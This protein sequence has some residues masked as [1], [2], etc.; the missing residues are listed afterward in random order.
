MFRSTFRRRAEIYLRF[1][2]DKLKYCLTAGFAYANAFPIKRISPPAISNLSLTPE[3]IKPLKFSIGIYSE[4]S[5]FLK[6]FDDVISDLKIIKLLE[7]KD[8]RLPKALQQI[9]GLIFILKSPTFEGALSRLMSQ[10]LDDSIPTMVYYIDEKRGVLVPLLKSREKSELPIGIIPQVHNPIVEVRQSIGTMIFNRTSLRTWGFREMLIGLKPPFIWSENRDAPEA[11]S[12]QSQILV[13]PPLRNSAE[14]ESLIRR[15]LAINV[16]LRIKYSQYILTMFPGIEFRLN[17]GRQRKLPSI[18]AIFRGYLDFRLVAQGFEH[19]T[20]YDTIAQMAQELTQT[21]YASSLWKNN[22]LVVCDDATASF[23][24][25]IKHQYGVSTMLV[26]SQEIRALDPSVVEANFDY[27]TRMSSAL[28]Y[29]PDYLFLKM[30]GFKYTSSDFVTEPSTE[31]G[32]PQSSATMANNPNGTISRIKTR[33][34]IEFFTLKSPYLLGKGFIDS[35][36]GVQFFTQM[37]ENSLEHA[38]N[39]FIL[40]IIVPVFNNGEYLL[41]KAIPSLLRNS[42]WNSMEIIIVDDGSTDVST[43]EVCQFLSR[44]FPNVKFYSFP[45]GGSGSASRARNKGMRLASSP[46]IS[47]LDPDNEISDQG[48]DKLLNRYFQANKLFHRCDFVSGYQVK[49]NESVSVNSLHSYTTWPTRIKNPRSDFF[50]SGRFP[51]V[52]TQAAVISKDFL[53]ENDLTFVHGAIGQDTLFGWQVL[54]S[55]ANPIFTRE[56]HLIYFAERSDSITNSVGV[57]FFEKSLRRE[58][59]QV[60]WLKS[61]GLFKIYCDQKYDY[62]F[63]RWYKLKLKQVK[64]EDL[65]QSANY[66]RQIAA[67]YN[68]DSAW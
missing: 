58:Q 3:N 50:E 11:K 13:A 59:A 49:I 43:L 21:P 47:F 2:V 10:C 25:S 30:V 68:K 46:T 67:L 26:T 38:A 36:Y 64:P 55:A 35:G 34:C 23:T 5:N 48:Y 45:P 22:I 66:L 9:D 42:N 52:S 40:S 1:A 14:S 4:D 62:F 33:N 56:A 17:G 60:Q 27:V 37:K 53:L 12:A 63:D 65:D 44:L 18:S 8:S 32:N 24:K 31:I 16:P 39:T 61:N 57:N 7:C 29:P 51:T 28:I 15:H 19:G 54:H 6:F 20:V 41:T